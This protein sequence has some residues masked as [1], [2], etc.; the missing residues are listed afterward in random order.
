MELFYS[1]PFCLITLLFHKIVMVRHYSTKMSWHLPRHICWNLTSEAH[2]M[3][4]I[5]FIGQLSI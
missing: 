2:S 3:N 5:N 4:P 1:S